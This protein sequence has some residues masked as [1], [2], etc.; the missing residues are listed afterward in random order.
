MDGGFGV[1]CVA[2]AEAEVR[3]ERNERQAQPRDIMGR[4]MEVDRRAEKS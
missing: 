3:R 1:N 2:E 4:R